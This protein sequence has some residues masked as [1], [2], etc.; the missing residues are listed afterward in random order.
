M[1]A[2]IFEDIGVSA[3]AGAAHLLS[4]GIVIQTAAAFLPPKQSTLRTLR[5]QIARLNISSPKL[6]GADLVPPPSGPQTQYLSIN[7]S[8]GLPAIRSVPQVLTLAYGGAGLT[9]G[10]FFPYGIN[11]AFTATASSAPATAANLETQPAG[12]A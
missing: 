6:D 8:N 7:T 10:G 12:F 5:T 1:L 9:K 4:T 2:R 11:G 3:Y